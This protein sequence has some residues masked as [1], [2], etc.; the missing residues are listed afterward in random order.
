LLRILH[1]V[2]DVVELFITTEFIL[3]DI[4]WVNIGSNINE[5]EVNIGILFGAHHCCPSATS[6]PTCLEQT[7]PNSNFFDIN[8]SK[9]EITFEE[10][11]IDLGLSSLIFV[12]SSNTSTIL[13]IDVHVNFLNP[14]NCSLNNGVFYFE[15]DVSQIEITNSY[16]FEL[17]TYQTV[18][19]RIVMLQ[20]EVPYTQMLFLTYHIQSF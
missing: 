6:I 3:H 14:V 1:Y 16:F 17:Y 19:F 8:I 9:C 10:E 7:P 15:G 13:T 12:R 20:K 2:D 5:E 18:F 11:Q 4:T